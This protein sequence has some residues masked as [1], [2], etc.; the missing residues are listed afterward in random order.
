M[1][2]R[3]KPPT[4]NGK[5]VIYIQHDKPTDPTQR[6]NWLPAPRKGF[7]FTTCLYGLNTLLI[8]GSYNLPVIV[9]VE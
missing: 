7:R 6:Q 1:L 5:L 3:G 9:R 4:K 8:D 2:A